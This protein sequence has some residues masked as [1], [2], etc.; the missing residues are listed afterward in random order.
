MNINEFEEWS[1]DRVLTKE[2]ME[3]Y[4]DLILSTDLADPSEVISSTGDLVLTRLGKVKLNPCL[5]NFQTYLKARCKQKY[6]KMIYNKRKKS[7]K[8]IDGGLS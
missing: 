5:E 8:L 1:S 6:D 3:L 2:E 4:E 7:F